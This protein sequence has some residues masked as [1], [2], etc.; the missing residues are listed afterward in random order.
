MNLQLPSEINEFVKRL[1]VQGRYESEE[2]AVVE[3]VKLLMSQ[4]S[5]RCEIQKGVAQLDDGQWFNEETVFDEVNEEIR[6]IEAA[7][8]GI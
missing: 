6:K 1:V 2:A 3:G 7:Q 5:L 4:E 8:Q